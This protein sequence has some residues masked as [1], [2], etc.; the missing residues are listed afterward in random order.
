MSS[1]IVYCNGQKV[2]L[3]EDS[4][5]LARGGEGTLFVK[6][7][8]I[9]KL[10][11]DVTHSISEEKIRELSVLDHPYIIRPIDILRNLHGINV[12]FTTKY[13]TDTIQ[14]CQLFST[15]Y[16]LDKHIT[17][18]I[19]WQLVDHIQ[20]VTRFI[21]N[22]KCLIADGNEANYLLD[23]NGYVSA[24]FIDVNSYQTPHFKV[25]AVSPLIMDPLVGA[26]FNENS[27]WFAYAIIICR[28]LLGIHPYRGMHPL[29][30]ERD[31]EKRVRDHISIFNTEVILPPSVRPWSWIPQSYYEW[32]KEVL[33]YGNRSDPPLPG[34]PYI[35]VVITMN[36]QVI[37]DSQIIHKYTVGKILGLHKI[38]FL[39]GVPLYIMK[40]N[41][42]RYIKKTY[43]GI[44]SSGIFLLSP[45]HQKLLYVTH[46]SC[47][48]TICNLDDNYSQNMSLISSQLLQSDDPSIFFSYSEGQ[49]SSV[50]IREVGKKICPVVGQTWKIL[51]KSSIVYDNVIYQPTLGMTYFII[52]RVQN[53]IPVCYTV[54]VPQLNT[55]R[56]IAAK[57]QSTVIQ[58]IGEKNGQYDRI[59]LRFSHNFGVYQCSIEEDITNPYINFC[60]KG[61]TI[62]VL[63]EEGSLTLYHLDYTKVQTE[64]FEHVLDPV[65]VLYTVND[66]VLFVCQDTVYTV[67]MT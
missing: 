45:I 61:R 30:S 17:Q 26:N 56:V 55:Y 14:M 38:V 29:Y 46:S 52:P 13:V 40:D 12:G 7:G 28:I 49:I 59:L 4:D 51:P 44:Y 25:K 19:L 60:I 58:I 32:M 34:K 5:F 65:G 53:G 37:G 10:Y 50:H 64:K 22:K 66:Q 62:L 63:D 3:D 39:N 16:L 24:Y 67:S 23:K 1:I 42:I 31:F 54:S 33:E 8:L 47:N 20:Q 48:I 9:Y 15:A 2:I 43:S 35:P 36:H 27:D 21:H 11:H 41:T 6:H 18:Q 57:A